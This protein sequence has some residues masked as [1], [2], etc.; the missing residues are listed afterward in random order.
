MLSM[1][2]VLFPMDFYLNLP[3]LICEKQKPRLILS[4]ELYF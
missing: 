3:T 1:T 4:C 2:N